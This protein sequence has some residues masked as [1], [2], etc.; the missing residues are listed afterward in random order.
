ML[1]GPGG[2]LHL[3]KVIVGRDFGDDIEIQAGSE[4]R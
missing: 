2:K 4:R 3:Q 1:V